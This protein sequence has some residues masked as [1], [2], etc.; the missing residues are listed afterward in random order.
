MGSASLNVSIVS[1]RQSDPLEAGLLEAGPLAGRRAAL[2]S[3]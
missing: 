2:A 1:L 3:V